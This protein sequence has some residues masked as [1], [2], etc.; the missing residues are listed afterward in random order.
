MHGRQAGGD[1]FIE[2]EGVSVGDARGASAIDAEAEVQE[3]DGC[4]VTVRDAPPYRHARRI[5]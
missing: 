2:A 3:R 4:G 5:G 1:G